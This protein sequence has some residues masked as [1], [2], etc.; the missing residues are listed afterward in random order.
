MPLP[1]RG[2]GSFGVFDGW[3]GI[4]FEPKAQNYAVVCLGTDG[5][6]E[7]KDP[8]SYPHGPTTDYA[9]DIVYSDGQFI[10]YPEGRSQL[11]GF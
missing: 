10:R 7:V 4:G 11:T 6:P 9:N 1:A 2:S 8:W 5:L 3:G